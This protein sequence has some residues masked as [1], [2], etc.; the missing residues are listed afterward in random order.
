MMFLIVPSSFDHVL[1]APALDDTLVR[2]PLFGPIVRQQFTYAGVRHLPAVSNTLQV[3]SY[4]YRRLRLVSPHRNA[5]VRLVKNRADRLQFIVNHR[6][7]RNNTFDFLLIAL[8]FVDGA[9]QG[10][11]RFRLPLPEGAGGLFQYFRI[12][13]GEDHFPLCLRPGPLAARG[14]AKLEAAR[15]L[16]KA[17]S[18]LKKIGTDAGRHSILKR[19]TIARKRH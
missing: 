17:G 12:I 15:L 5:V 16:Y 14:K 6:L 7:E 4:D 13:A 2:I 8:Q 18:R 19:S 9:E 10:Y 1:A 3:S 11:I